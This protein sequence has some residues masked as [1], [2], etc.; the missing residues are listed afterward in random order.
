MFYS[1]LRELSAH[2]KF[3]DLEED[4]IKDIF[5]CNIKNSNIKSTGDIENKQ[6]KLEYSLICLPKQTK[7]IPSKHTTK[8]KPMLEMRGHILH[9]SST[10]IPCKNNYMQSMQKTGTLHII[11]YS[12]NAR[13]PATRYATK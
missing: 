10:N 8:T 2:C 13:T 9:S 12:K 6:H 5:I 3:K 11:V 4:L 7:N 1:H